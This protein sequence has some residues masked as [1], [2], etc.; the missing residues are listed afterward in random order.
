VLGGQDLSQTGTLSNYLYTYDKAGRLTSAAETPAG[1]GCTTRS[2]TFDVDSNRKSLITRAPGVG[3]ACSWSGGTTQSYKYD[4]ADRLEG[5]TYDSWGRI[6]SLPAEFAGGKALTT[7]YFSTDMVAKQIQSGVTNTFQLDGALRQRQRVQAGGIEG[8]EVFHYDSSSDSPAWTQLGSTWTRSI[9]GIGGA[10][11]AVQESGSGTT[12]R[13]TNMHGDV[14]AKASI[15][16]MET[17]LLATYRFDEFGNPLAGSAGA[18]RLARRAAAQNG[19]RF[20]GDP[21]GSA[22]LH[23]RSGSLY[24]P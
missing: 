14:V 8:V 17:K 9:V 10:L 2:Y 22:E 21:D 15:S 23:S 24:Q 7:S 18:V 13:L 4:M 20:R 3:G 12:L 11:S 16:P 5:P 6:T 19:T 1:G